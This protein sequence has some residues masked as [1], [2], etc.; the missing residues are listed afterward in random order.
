MRIHI[1]GWQI[2]DFRRLSSRGVTPWGGWRAS[3]RWSRFSCPHSASGGGRCTCCFASPACLRI[4]CGAI[5]ARKA[6]G[7]LVMTKHCQVSSYCSL[8]LFMPRKLNT[9]LLLFSELG[10]WFLNEIFC[11]RYWSAQKAFFGHFGKIQHQAH[12]GLFQL[13]P[14]SLP[15]QRC[16]YVKNLQDISQCF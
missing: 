3:R 5:L 12:V 11:F 16:R 8:H 2:D 1:S 13:Y 10:A 9:P 4:L 14:S 15:C 7:R 6:A